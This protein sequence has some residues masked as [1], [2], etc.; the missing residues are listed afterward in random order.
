MLNPAHSQARLQWESKDQ[1]WTTRQ[2]N[3]MFFIW[4][5][6]CFFVRNG[7]VKTNEFQVLTWNQISIKHL[8]DVLN[9]EVQSTEDP[10]HNSKG[11]LIVLV[12]MSSWVA[13]ALTAKGEAHNSGH[14]I[15][16]LGLLSVYLVQLHF[17]S[18][19]CMK[20]C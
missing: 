10:P 6:V 14:V 8:W 2:R 1:N 17:H 15:V 11:L 5:F 12:S 7:I 3:G 13:A 16:V 18:H 19:L 9:K 4:S 20:A